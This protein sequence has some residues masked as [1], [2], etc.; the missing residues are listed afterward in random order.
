LALQEF[1]TI[2]LIHIAH[3]KDAS[4]VHLILFQKFGHLNLKVM[5]NILDHLFSTT[6]ILGLDVLNIFLLPSVESHAA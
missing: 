4:F 1:T 2:A 6:L 3:M 5:G